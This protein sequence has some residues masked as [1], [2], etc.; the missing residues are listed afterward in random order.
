MEF[1]HDPVTDEAA[2]QE[3]RRFFTDVKRRMKEAGSSPLRIATATKVSRTTLEHYFSGVEKGQRFRISDDT[4]RRLA[5]WAKLDL[6]S[7]TFG[8]V[9]RNGWKRQPKEVH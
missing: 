7:Y 3:L 6:A 9:P 5:G 8:R 1:E 4:A 2:Y